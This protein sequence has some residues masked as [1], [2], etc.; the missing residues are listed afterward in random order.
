MI[1][2]PLLHTNNMSFLAGK[3]LT[4]DEQLKNNKEMMKAATRELD[5]EIFNIDF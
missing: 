1:I 2:I 5:K 3:K 4:M